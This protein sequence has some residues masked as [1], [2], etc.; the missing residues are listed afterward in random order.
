MDT[1][2]NSVGNRRVSKGHRLTPYSCTFSRVR[3]SQQRTQRQT[4]TS[5]RLLPSTPKFGIDR[6]HSSKQEVKVSFTDIIRKQWKVFSLSPLFNFKNKPVLLKKY[7]RS[8]DAAFL[9]SHTGSNSFRST[10]SVY[11]GLS[12]HNKDPE[13]IKIDIVQ[14]LSE[15]EE[16]VVLS[17]LMMCV[18]IDYTDHPVSPDSRTNFTYYPVLLISGNISR[19][20]TFITWLEMHF[21]CHASP[22]IFNNN[23]LKCMLAMWSHVKGSESLPVLMQ[24]SLKNDNIGIGTIDCKI[25]SMFCKQYWQRFHSDIS[26]EETI[27]ESLMNAFIQSLETD[28]QYR[29][30]ICFSKLNLSEI[31]T[32]VAYVSGSGKLKLLSQMHVYLALH[33]ICV[34]SS[35]RFLSIDS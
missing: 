28:L 31:G 11:P 35:N 8:L 27:D 19:T 25:D 23:N 14:K 34:I 6:S 29:M 3:K 12:V 5:H 26:K 32:P 9:Q 17:A 33:L 7:S 30:S 24:Y 4:P 22:M 18:D 21:D 16:K 1:P 10:F 2:N 13:A 15:T 20:D